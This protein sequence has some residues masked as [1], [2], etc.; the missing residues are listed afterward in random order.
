M[1]ESLPTTAQELE[2]PHVVPSAP[3]GATFALV[4][5][6]HHSSVE[7]GRS[8]EKDWPAKQYEDGEQDCQPF[9]HLS[10]PKLLMHYRSKKSLRQTDCKNIPTTSQTARN[11]LTLEPLTNIEGCDRLAVSELGLCFP[12]F[13]GMSCSVENRRPKRLYQSNKTSQKQKKADL[14]RT[15]FFIF[16]LKRFQ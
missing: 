6:V 5:S 14:P 9:R 7:V 1:S 8:Y 10:L 4:F 16:V 15:A 12:W 2:S 13:S 11:E 3:V